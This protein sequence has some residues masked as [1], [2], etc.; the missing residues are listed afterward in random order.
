[1]CIYVLWKQN[2]CHVRSLQIRCWIKTTIVKIFRYVKSHKVSQLYFLESSNMAWTKQ[3]PNS[4]LNLV[5][6]RPRQGL[7]FDD[8]KTNFVS[9]LFVIIRDDLNFWCGLFQEGSEKARSLFFR[10]WLTQT[11]FPCWKTTCF[12]VKMH[13]KC[14]FKR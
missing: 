5:L 14:C 4:L 3:F 12:T 2:L 7:F 8:M 1:M 9:Y 6:F 11:L 10:I 13:L